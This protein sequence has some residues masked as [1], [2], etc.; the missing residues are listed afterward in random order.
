MTHLDPASQIALRMRLRDIVARRP[1]DLRYEPT[2]LSDAKC[3]DNVASF[4]AR[5]RGHNGFR[6]VGGWLSVERAEQGMVVARRVYPHWVV[7]DGEDAMIDVTPRLQPNEVHRF[8]A[9]DDDQAD[10]ARLYRLISAPIELT[11]GVD[12]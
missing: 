9:H 3:E 4:L 5:Y 10:F 1:L 7:A 8:H 6:R 12:Y 11:R 2:P